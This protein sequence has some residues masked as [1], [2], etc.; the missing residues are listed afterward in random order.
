[1]SL[2]VGIDSYVT[3]EEANEYISKHFAS[4][5]KLLINWNE[6]TDNDKE[7]KLRESCESI[8]NLKFRGKRKGV[9]QELEFPRVLGSMCGIG[10]RLYVSQF[11]DNGLI[12]ND[13]TG[14]GGIKLA[15]RA[16]IVNALYGVTLGSEITSNALNR[17]KRLTSKKAGP[18]SETYGGSS[19]YSD[20][21]MVG[22]YTEQV[23][24]ILQPWLSNSRVTI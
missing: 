2:E 11:V 7:A 13:I 3:L 9:G 14:D 16:Q 12:S 6:R 18:I 20:N 8:N 5:D 4:D 22:I 19:R 24:A 1:M 21:A 10:F 17:F 23:Y 15:K